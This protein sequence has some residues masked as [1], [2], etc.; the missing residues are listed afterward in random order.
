MN[1]LLIYPYFLDERIHSDDIAVPPIGLYYVA[2]MLMAHGHDVSIFNAHDLAGEADR[3][4]AV[5]RK[6]KPDV[7]GFSILHANRWGGIDLARL[8]KQTLPGTPVVFGGIGAT[9]LWRHLLAHFPEID[10][11]VCGEGEHA[12]L[13]LVQHLEQ[14]S[15]DPPD[16]IPGVAFRRP[17][18]TLHLTPAAP[19]H[20]NL[21]ELP[22]PAQYFPFQHLVMSRGCPG[23]CT[24]CGSPAFWQRRVRFHSADY[25]A[26]QIERLTRR[27]IRF[28]Y[29]SDDTFTLRK[30]RVIDLCRQLIE[31]RLDISWSAISRVDAVDEEVLYWMRKAGCI[32]ISY[33]VEHGS[34]SIR[35][36]FNKALATDQIRRA[37]D[38][39]V[40]HGIL[41]RAYFIYGC[42]GENRDSI[43]KT[44]DLMD[45]IKPLSAIFY[46]LDLFPGTA[47][48][49]AYLSESGLTDDDLWLNRVEDILYYETDDALSADM[50][51]G[52]GS[53]L[54]THLYTRLPEYVRAVEL[55]DDDRLAAEHAD[56]LS[57]LAM[58]FDL[59]DYA[60]NS[61]IPEKGLLAEM[62]YR[63]AL[64]YAP[65]AR[66]Y[67]GLGIF[68]QKRGD[69]AASIRIL[70][71][72]I[73]AFSDDAS[74]SICLGLSFMNTGYPQHA[75][76]CLLPFADREQA[77]S[78]IVQCYD[79]MGDDVN[80]NRFRKPQGG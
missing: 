45:E 4:G 18:G 2:A 68:E 78:M 26:D 66:A 21:D 77:R 79:A 53:T 80:A 17:D 69:Y 55:V 20:R 49:E 35:R 71:E 33:G 23:N 37:F 27:G 36:R 70:T 3:I 65:V 28:F 76:D 46:I 11:V 25:I 19:F 30:S 42:P 24:F 9:L 6:S 75:L 12:L 5:Y 54:R 52:Y 29:F 38:L 1:I 50:V 39:T 67:L 22:D 44:L 64:T 15:D 72:G 8:A 16:G 31:R 62:L 57:R 63:R 58:T 43:Q 59:G 56:F 41:S 40:R 51:R 61:Q 60:D 74:L 13:R 48:Y 14:G 32:Q 34:A 10:M 7:I 47:L 73:E